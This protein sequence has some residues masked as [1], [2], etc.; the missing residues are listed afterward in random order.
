MSDDPQ[1]HPTPQEPPVTHNPDV[2]R[3]RAPRPD[4]FA[5][6]TPQ[7]TPAVARSALP[8]LPDASTPGL[9]GT[10]RTLTLSPADYRSG[11]ARKRVRTFRVSDSNDELDEILN[12]D[13]GESRYII[14]D[15]KDNFFEG[16][17]Y[18]TLTYTE[19][20]KK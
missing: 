15:R 12:G 8:S 20:H 2:P 17:S 19:L 13:A 18:V 14:E 16:E 3:L 5:L 9:P 11:A 10:N 6:H 4:R 1:M 7:A